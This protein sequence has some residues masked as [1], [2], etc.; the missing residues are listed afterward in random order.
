MP[1]GARTPIPGA[2]ALR[3]AAIIGPL[4]AIPAGTLTGLVMAATAGAGIIA[5]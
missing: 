2:M 5:R 4:T 1:I 3:T